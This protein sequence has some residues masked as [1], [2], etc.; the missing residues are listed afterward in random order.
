VDNNIVVHDDSAADGGD[1]DD[2]DDDNN[3]TVDI[4][5]VQQQQLFSPFLF[6]FLSCSPFSQQIIGLNKQPRIHQLIFGE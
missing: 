6:L 1:D 4:E 3:D 5:V 2:G